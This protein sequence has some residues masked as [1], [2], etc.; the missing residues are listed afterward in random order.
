MS[1][2]PR[3]STLPFQTD[4]SA[5]ELTLRRRQFLAELEGGLAVL[6]SAPEVPGYDPIRQ[7]NDFYYLTGI[8]GSHAYLTLDV[9]SGR[10]V[11]YL[12]PHDPKHEKSD[13]PTLCHEDGDAVRV[14]T[15]IDEVRPL[16]RLVADLTGLVGTLWLAHAPAENIRQCQDTLR[17]WQRRIA[18]DPL[19]ARPSREAHLRDRITALSPGVL[20]RDFSPALHR[21]RLQKSPAELTL[22]RHAATLTALACIEAMKA[23]RPGV[24]EYQLGA[25]ADYVFLAAGARSAGYR[26]IIATGAN[27]WMMH[28]WRNNTALRAG[29][30]VLF[31]YAPDFR[32]YTSDIGRMWPVNGTY[33]PLQRELYGFVLEHHNLLLSLIRPHVTKAQVLAEAA[34]KLRPVVQ[35]RS[36]SK[37]VY[38][39][40]ALRLLESPR[41]LSHGVGMP[42]HESAA[43]YDRPMSPGLVF[44]LDPELVVPEEELYI[45]VED[46]VVVTED[47]C[48][49][50]T[51]GCPREIDEVEALL[52]ASV[53]DCS[54]LIQHLPPIAFV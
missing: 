20:V 25:V 31:D 37:P 12:P 54:G 53:A 10:G 8:E 39:T 5:S 35:A 3:A 47:G 17:H 32:Y 45:R 28:Y 38:R 34:E 44:A 52:R 2:S 43:W 19:D 23:S 4:F 6:A 9:Q 11:L 41:P 14:R 13:G 18:A 26:P 7:D 29:D 1:N 48:E 22:M 15:G 16:S 50:L 36:W 51:A 30:L 42:V 21:Q 33:S 49:N 40:A 46:T 24:F 27:I